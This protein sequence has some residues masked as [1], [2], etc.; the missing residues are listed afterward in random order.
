MLK[1]F[2]DKSCVYFS[3]KAV[4]L[5]TFFSLKGWN[6]DDL[7]PNKLFLIFTWSVWSVWA[8]HIYYQ[9]IH[10]NFWSILIQVT[11]NIHL[12]YYYAILKFMWLRPICRE[13][14]FCANLQKKNN[15]QIWRHNASTPCSSDITDQLW[16]RHNTK[17]EKTVLSDNG[18]ISYR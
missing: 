3:I 14:R 9:L 6:A 5:M 13:D 17:S 15:R 1:I 8:L 12:K 18:E 16:W 4:K 2:W 11:G 7:L 10:E